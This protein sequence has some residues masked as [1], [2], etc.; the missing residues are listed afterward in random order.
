MLDAHNAAAA[1]IEAEHDVVATFEPTHTLDLIID[2]IRGAQGPPSS[3]F[4]PLHTPV[5][6]APMHEASCTEAAPTAPDS[7]I[8]APESS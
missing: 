6:V 1:K 2:H 3:L 4:L 5:T 7:S 8:L